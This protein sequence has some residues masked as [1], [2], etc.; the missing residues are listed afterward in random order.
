[1]SLPES[2]PPRGTIGR[3]GSRAWLACRHRGT[4][5]APFWTVRLRHFLQATAASSTALGAQSRA[6]WPRPPRRRC[7]CPA[8][9]PDTLAYNSICSVYDEC[10]TVFRRHIRSNRSADL[11]PRSRRPSATPSGRATSSVRR[12]RRRRCALTSPGPGLSARTRP[13]RWTWARG[14]LMWPQSVASELR[15][16]GERLRPDWMVALLYRDYDPVFPGGGFDSFLR[17]KAVGCSIRC[18]SSDVGS[19]IIVVNG[20][21]SRPWRRGGRYSAEARGRREGR[22]IE[23]RVA[24]RG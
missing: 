14:E 18:F 4:P 16:P 19:S 21:R 23:R 3:A 13:S 8:C 2:L 17:V 11:T 5:P 6:T 20:K 12:P 22:A 15:L 9:P 7:A 1:L 10:F 24:C